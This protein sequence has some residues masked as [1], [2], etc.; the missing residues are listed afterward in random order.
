MQRSRPGKRRTKVRLCLDPRDLNKN[1]RR[2]HYY[3]RTIDEILP[4]L[5]GKQYFSVI[6]TKKGYWHVKLLE[7]SSLLCTFNTPFGRYKFNRLQ[8]GVRLCQDVFQKKLDRAHEGIPNVTGIADDIIVSGSNPKERDQA[9]V[10]MLQA[11][12]K[13]KIGLNSEKLQ[14]N[15]S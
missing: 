3:S 10:A 14:F 2:K 1:I 13:N 9:L 11:S 5:H 12:C 6:D 8:F 4:Q 7:E 15:A